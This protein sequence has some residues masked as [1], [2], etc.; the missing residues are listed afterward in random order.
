M[1]LCLGFHSCGA[2][3][4][5]CGSEQSAKEVYQQSE[6]PEIFRRLIV[7]L[8]FSYCSIASRLVVVS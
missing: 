7:A 8:F 2:G 1:M 5:A 6:A 3:T 4:P